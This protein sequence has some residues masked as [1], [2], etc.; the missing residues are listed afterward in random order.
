M[1][2]IEITILVLVLAL[3]A[4]VADTWIRR[5][6]QPRSIRV[7]MA[8][9]DVVPLLEREPGYAV[10]ECGTVLHPRLA[11]ELSR[12]GIDVEQGV[13]AS[14]ES[15]F[16][17]V[18]R[19]VEKPSARQAPAYYGSID[20]LFDP[21]APRI[22]GLL[23]LLAGA[24]YIAALGTPLIAFTIRD[25]LAWSMAAVCLFP[26]VLLAVTALIGLLSKQP[27]G[28]AAGR[29]PDGGQS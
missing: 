20:V 22:Y 21:P 13:L 14:Y 7:R 10:D 4:W 28:D 23:Q 1:D 27:R 29:E 8:L 2:G 26:G 25:P 17:V 9:D 6:P 18:F 24:V 5:P 11:E 3:L 12:R 19:G 16:V 15:E